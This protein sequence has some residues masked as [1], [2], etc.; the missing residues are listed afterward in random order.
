MINTVADLKRAADITRR[1]VV[2]LCP[3]LLIGL[4]SA[5]GCSGSSTSPS[6]AAAGATSPAA[7]VGRGQFALTTPMGVATNG[8]C[9]SMNSIASPSLDWSFQVMPGHTATVVIDATSFHDPAAGCNPNNLSTTTPRP[10]VVSGPHLTY[11]PGETGTTTFSFMAE[12]C[13]DGGRYGISIWALTEEAS[14]TDADR[15][16]SLTVVDCG[17][18]SPSGIP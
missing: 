9:I 18:P 4:V 12:R 15:M 7:S 17:F 8:A 16:S 6:A 13:K 3:I 11:A 2:R 10:L 5:A 1:R 14:E